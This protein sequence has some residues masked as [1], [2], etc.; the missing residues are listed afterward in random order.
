MI[1]Y[2]KLFLKYKNET[3]RYENVSHTGDGFFM[4]FN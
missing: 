1:I 3:N 4:V 2:K